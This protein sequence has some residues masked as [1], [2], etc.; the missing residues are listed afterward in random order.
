MEEPLIPFDV[1]DDVMKCDS[2]NY[3]DCLRVM[4]K[5]PKEPHDVLLFILH[6][7]CCYLDHKGNSLSP[8]GFAICF[9][10]TLIRW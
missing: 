4:N 9:A 1:Y 2:N 10:P 6:L 5:L 3:E 7:L 8:Q